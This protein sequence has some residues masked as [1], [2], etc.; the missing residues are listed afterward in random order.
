[1]IH[2]AS[3]PEVLKKYLTEGRK[4]EEIVA[5]LIEEQL[6]GKCEKSNV[7][8]DKFSHID[9][10]WDSPKMG[11]IGIDVK[12]RNK[13]KRTDS[14]FSDNHW[15]EAQNVSGNKGWI[16]GKMTYIAFRTKDKILFVKPQQLIDLYEQT[17]KGQTPSLYTPK[18]NYI[19]YTRKLF[20]NNDLAWRMPDSDLEKIAQFSIDLDIKGDE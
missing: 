7:R 20:N 8:E 5:N 10:W 15:I 6:G 18:D 16:Y 19:L 4:D 17:L 14:E 11:R 1:M 12:G 9:L 13:N 3:N 2:I